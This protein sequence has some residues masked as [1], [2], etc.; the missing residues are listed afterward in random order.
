MYICRA[1]V[2]NE[3]GRLSNILLNSAS[4]MWDA[5]DRTTS[6]TYSSCYAISPFSFS[7]FF[8]SF[9][10]S[11]NYDRLF[12]SNK[13]VCL[14]LLLSSNNFVSFDLLCIRFD[15]FCSCSSSLLFW[16]HVN[17]HDKRKSITIHRHYG[18][19]INNRNDEDAPDIQY[20]YATIVCAPV[21]L[22]VV[23]L[24]FSINNLLLPCV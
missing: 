21:H 13:C 20:T 5:D 7:S 10:L 14:Q 15:S 23:I 19:I 9:S 11:F 1:Q 16:P 22:V 17:K 18:Y 24:H 3:N 2:I 6:C 4:I 8:R 12:K